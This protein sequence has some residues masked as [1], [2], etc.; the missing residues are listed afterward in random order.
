[1]HLRQGPGDAQPGA[2]L[3][4]VKLLDTFLM[5]RDLQNNLAMWVEHMH[6]V[7][8]RELLVLCTCFIKD[9]LTPSL[10]IKALPPSPAQETLS[11][12]LALPLKQPCRVLW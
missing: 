1:M 8:P 11:H 9:A 6:L 10:R 12:F 5:S 4:D 2:P 7:R 3:P